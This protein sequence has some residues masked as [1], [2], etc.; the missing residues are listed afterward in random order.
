MIKLYIFLLL[1]LPIFCTAQYVEESTVEQDTLDRKAVKIIEGKSIVDE[2]LKKANNKLKSNYST[3]KNESVTTLNLINDNLLNVGKDSSVEGKAESVKTLILLQKERVESIQGISSMSTPSLGDLGG[4]LQS[5]LKNKEIPLVENKYTDS[6]F[7]YLEE[8]K[9][10]KEVYHNIDSLSQLEGEL[11]R[12][13]AKREVSKEI[14]Q[15]KEKVDDHKSVRAVF[16]L[17]SI[18]K[19]N[20]KKWKALNIE[21][22]DDIKEKLE[23]LEKKDF[24][25]G[26]KLPEAFDTLSVARFSTSSFDP[27]LILKEK[28][29]MAKDGVKK[30]Y[31]QKKQLFQLP[32]NMFFNLNLSI[33][34]F[35]SL[36]LQL[37][38]K[39]GYKFKFGLA[40][41]T[42]LIINGQAYPYEKAF[43]I[44]VGVK[45]TLSYH[46]PKF[47]KLGVV[48]DHILA[49]KSI[50]QNTEYKGLKN[51][52]SIILV[53]PSLRIPIMGLVD[54]KFAI[55][56]NVLEKKNDFFIDENW[57]IDLG[58]TIFN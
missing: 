40:I 31:I 35:D 7:V 39:I 43:L 57:N 27:E 8:V 42:G 37:T 4:N 36:G 52:D 1:I 51:W 38:P 2:E 12:F 41:S 48:C 49:Q 44:K 50:D 30:Y 26:I 28:E 5:K 6:A 13:F 11:T 56:Y 25:N 55:K 47:N 10:L 46:Y 29:K 3:L 21:S 9:R 33:T 45:N 54:F 18:R 15:L 16:Y 53:G 22:V 19:S 20:R 24:K 23:Q 17:D 14:A 58:F 32:K 34:S